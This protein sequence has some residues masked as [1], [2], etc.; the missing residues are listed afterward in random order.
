MAAMQL[1]SE[2]WQRKRLIDHQLL[3]GAAKLIYRSQSE[4]IKQ[5][6]RKVVVISIPSL[7]QNGRRR[8]GAMQVEQRQT[9]WDKWLSWR[10]SY[11]RPLTAMNDAMIIS[12][13]AGK[14]TMLMTND[15]GL[16]TYYISVLVLAKITATH[17]WGID[18]THEMANGS[19]QTKF[20]DLT[21]PFDQRFCVLRF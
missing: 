6:Q 13:M 15:K 10:R 17:S 16:M 20:I 9:G 5:L 8:Y 12:E 19:C 4:N 3:L 11:F 2:H 18:I 14:I 1:Q 7:R 21:T